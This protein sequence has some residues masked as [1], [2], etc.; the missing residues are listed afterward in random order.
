MLGNVKKLQITFYYPSS[1]ISLF[2]K[3]VEPEISLLNQLSN[4]NSK[5]CD[6]ALR[7]NSSTKVRCSCFPKNVQEILK[8]ETPF[9]ER[10]RRLRVLHS[11]SLIPRLIKLLDQYSK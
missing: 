2:P 7:C 5:T 11:C 4:V 8:E 1:P 6:S 9:L 3:M 10:P